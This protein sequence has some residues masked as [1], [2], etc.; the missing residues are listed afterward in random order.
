[1]ISNHHTGSKT[2]I[3]SKNLSRIRE[4]KFAA[5]LEYDDD[6]QAKGGQNYTQHLKY[7]ESKTCLTKGKMLKT[8]GKPDTMESVGQ[9]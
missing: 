9:F 4:R 8:C 6:F 3:V 2:G 1:M 5:T 7:A